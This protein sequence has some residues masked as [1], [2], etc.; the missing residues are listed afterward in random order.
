MKTITLL[1]TAIVL[2]L[3]A[4]AEEQFVPSHALAAKLRF[5]ALRAGED[6]SQFD[7]TKAPV[8]TRAEMRAA[9]E[10]RRKARVAKLLDEYEAQY[11]Q[12]VA[13]NERTEDELISLIKA[14]EAKVDAAAEA[15]KQAATESLTDSTLAKA[16]IGV[17][18]LL[19]GLAAS[20]LFLRTRKSLS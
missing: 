17:G 8:V 3:S 1:V 4:H 16:G 9:E 13:A 15:N 6:A 2:G 7:Y 20:G 5:E 10:A 18:G 11:E 19:A 14:L 12:H